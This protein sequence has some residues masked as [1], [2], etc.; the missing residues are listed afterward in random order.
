[1]IVKTTKTVQM[2]PVSENTSD[3]EGDD[4]RRSRPAS[5]FER[6]KKSKSK[7]KARRKPTSVILEDANPSPFA[8]CVKELQIHPPTPR[9]KA[10]AAIHTKDL[11]RVLKTFHTATHSEGTGQKWLPNLERFV[12]VSHGDLDKGGF[13]REMGT[14]LSEM[15]VSYKVEPLRHVDFLFYV[16][17]APNIT[18]WSI[19][20]NP[21]KEDHI[22]ALSRIVDS[23]CPSHRSSFSENSQSSLAHMHNPSAID[24]STRFDSIPRRDSRWQP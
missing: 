24:D 20:I 16:A 23:V 6:R 15:C 22:A 2:D 8:S 13:G 18:S 14:L 9:H 5:R 10:N 11:A 4:D 1:M 17:R 12:W 3:S 19:P 7:S 21:T